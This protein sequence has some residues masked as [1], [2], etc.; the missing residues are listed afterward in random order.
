MHL[1]HRWASRNLS[2]LELVAAILVLALVMAAFLERGLRV[3]AAAEGRSLHAT[4]LNMNSALRILFYQ[5][6][7]A[8]RAAEVAQWQGMNPVQILENSGIP[9]STE[10]MM[11]YP[12]LVRFHAMASGLGERYAGEFDDPDPESIVGGQWYYDRSESLLVYRIRSY[13]FFRSPLP[14]SA[15]IRFRLNVQYNPDSQIP[16]DVILQSV[17]EYQWIEADTN[18]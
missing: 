18:L 11:E 12:E 13:E 7:I 2:R 3:F 10:T 8:D 6:V 16:A 1:A 14:G 17:D 4:V 5:L 9:I 15:R